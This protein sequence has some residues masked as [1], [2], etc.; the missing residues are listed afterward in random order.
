MATEAKNAMTT[1]L[2]NNWTT[3]V[4]NHLQAL[5]SSVPGISEKHY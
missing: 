3:K 2:R 5:F 1:E 4:E